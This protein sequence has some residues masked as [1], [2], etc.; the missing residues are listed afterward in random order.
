MKR[1]IVK[2]LCDAF[3][4]GLTRSRT[5]V[6][7]IVIALA[8]PVAVAD[9]TGG[10]VQMLTSGDRV[11]V[12]VVGRR[13][14]LRAT[15]ESVTADEI[16]L[17]PQDAA[18]P[19]RVDLAQLESLDVARGRRSH[20]LKGA[21]IGLGTGTLL[22]GLAGGTICGT[23]GDNTGCPFDWNLGRLFGLIGGV[24]TTPVGA[25]AGLAFRT[26]RWER[27]HERKPKV[28]LVIAPAKG[29]TRFG[30]SVSF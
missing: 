8:V 20:W 30:L 10:S 22:F 13:K 25:L 5:T 26:D 19:L 17:R 21:V 3:A 4:R 14:T 18:G 23:Y 24:V 27:V 12:E 15:V 28:S 29:E 16:V 1:D 11:R 6:W 7:L 9:D 2:G